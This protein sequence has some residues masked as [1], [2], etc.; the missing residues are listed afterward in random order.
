[1][2]FLALV[3]FPWLQPLNPSTH[4]SKM[5]QLVINAFTLRQQQQEFLLNSLQRQ[6]QQ[7]QQQQQRLQCQQPCQQLQ[8]TNARS[9]AA[10]S[11]ALPKQ[12][13]TMLPPSPQQHPI[14]QQ[15]L[16][17]A[18]A[19]NSLYTSQPSV[20]TQFSAAHQ[21]FNQVPG[22][23]CSMP[24]SSRRKQFPAANLLDGSFPPCSF[25]SAAFQAT[26]K[27]RASH[28]TAP[29]SG[30]GLLQVAQQ[31]TLQ[32]PNDQ[33]FGH[34]Q[35]MEEQALFVTFP[36]NMPEH[37]QLASANSSS[38]SGNNLEL[39]LVTCD[40]GSE[41]CKKTRRR[42][43]HAAR[44]FLDTCLHA[45]ECCWCTSAY[46]CACVCKCVSGCVCMMT[47]SAPEDEE[48]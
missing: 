34:D 12:S 1:M 2:Q 21:G 10:G 30:P 20:A 32:T 31:M 14:Y 24:Q 36:V 22:A 3:H 39:S 13:S 7:Q 46:P 19:C 33:H 18:Q 4:I 29:A 38:T 6:K 23:P 41:E 15:A 47:L 25:A 37:T 43:S 8:H 44:D 40:K 16:P 5:Q 27:G 17:D 35:Q 11:H 26:A 42:L 45:K 48:L 9:Q 28:P